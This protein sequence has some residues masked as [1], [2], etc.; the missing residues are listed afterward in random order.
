M[1]YFAHAPNA[2]SQP[3]TTVIL[4]THVGLTGLENVA[5]RYRNAAVTAFD[6]AF[7]ACFARLCSMSAEEVIRAPHR[8]LYR[9]QAEGEFPADPHE[10][11]SVSCLSHLVEFLRCD[12]SADT[13]RNLVSVGKAS[14]RFI[15]KNL[16]W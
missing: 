12:R 11:Y 10:Q 7:P 1:D 2:L 6:N 4:P 9:R 13:K 3:A 8:R 14:G 15:Q 16:A 5:S